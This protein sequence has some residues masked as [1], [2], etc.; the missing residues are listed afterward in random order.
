VVAA[1]SGVGGRGL[2]DIA[3]LPSL[4]VSVSALVRKR[5]RLA[6]R[7]GAPPRVSG[8]RLPQTSR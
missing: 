8:A 4:S 5:V 2:A 3:V 6:R 1:R 7:A